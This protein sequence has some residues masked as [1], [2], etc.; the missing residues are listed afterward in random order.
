MAHPAKDNGYSK[1]VIYY[2]NLHFCKLPFTPH[3][4]FWIS[5]FLEAVGNIKSVTKNLCLNMNNK[6]FNFHSHLYFVLRSV[7]SL[8]LSQD[9]LSLICVKNFLISLKF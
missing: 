3:K 2:Q 7:A 1:F 5:F 4:F 8:I 6:Y 9:P